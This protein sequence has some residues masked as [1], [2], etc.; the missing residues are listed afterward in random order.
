[1]AKCLFETVCCRI[2]QMGTQGVKEENVRYHKL[3]SNEFT[4]LFLP[5]CKELNTLAFD[6]HD[7]G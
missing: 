6:C 3:C 2:V 4:I 7:S 1:M 5:V